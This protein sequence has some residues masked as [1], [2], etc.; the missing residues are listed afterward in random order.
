MKLHN[1]KQN[2]TICVFCVLVTEFMDGVLWYGSDKDIFEYTAVYND[3]EFEFQ[4]N[5]DLY[6]E[7]LKIWN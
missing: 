2:G 3:E 7:V 1:G 6:S 5:E 4:K